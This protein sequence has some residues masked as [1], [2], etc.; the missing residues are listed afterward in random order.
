LEELTLAELQAGLAVGKF[1]AVELVRL[2]TERIR[3]LD[4]QGPSLKAVIELNPE[5]EAIAASLDAERLAKSTRG[6]LHGIPVLIKDNIDTHDRM[7]TSAGSLALTDSIAPRDAFL[8]ER[9]RAAGAVILG[10]TNLS[11]WANF[12]GSRSISGWSARGGQTRNPY[13]TSHGPSGSSSGSAVAVSASFCA[14]AVGTETNGSIVSPASHCGIV[15]LKPTVGLISRT[16][17]IPIAATMDTAGPMTRTVADAALLLG[18]LA[19]ADPRDDATQ[20]LSGKP[21]MD[22]TRFLDINALRGARLGVLRNSFRMHPKVDPAFAAALASLQQSGAEL[23]VVSLPTLP[24][25]NEARYQVMLYEFKAGLNAY[26]ASL[27]AKAPVQDIEALIAF[28]ERNKEREL[29]FFG[30]EILLEAATKGPLTEPAY[31]AA[32]A[33]VRE[34]AKVFSAYLDEQRV[35]AIVAPTSGPAG[36]LDY[37]HGDRSLGGSSTPAATAGF[38]HITVPCGQVYGLPVGLS[39]YGRAWSEPKLL[40]LAYSFE[41]KTKARFVPKFQARMELA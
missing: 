33:R 20:P 24:G 11:E 14:V 32:K 30:Q 23:V 19:G 21:P 10:K 17:I 1:T 9:L 6:P 26:F 8:V 7:R 12:R 27:G 36:A 22:Y 34:W 18:V 40:A 31:L 25:L 38:P 16:G 4:Q 3:S 15:G 37:L 28:N 13:F 35:E 29:P 41:Q 2:Y 5:A 39:F